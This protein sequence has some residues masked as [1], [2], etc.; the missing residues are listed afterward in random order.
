LEELCF[1]YTH[2]YRYQVLNREIN[3]RY[4]NLKA[5]IEKIQDEIKFRLGQEGLANYQA[6][7]RI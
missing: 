4:G 5:I 1:E 6:L 3:K 2:P 7:Q